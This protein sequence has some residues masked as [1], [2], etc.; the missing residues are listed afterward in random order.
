M[1]EKNPLFLPTSPDSAP[2]WVSGPKFRS[3]FDL[4]T[5]CILTLFLCVWTAVHLNIPG[6]EQ[7]R[8]SRLSQ[9]N[10]PSRIGW[11]LTGLIA[12]EIVL[13]VAWQQHTQAHI[14]L[15]QLEDEWS[16]DPAQVKSY[17]VG[18]PQ[19]RV[20][21]PVGSGPD[22]ILPADTANNGHDQERIKQA[23]TKK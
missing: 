7:R 15:S 22:S 23:Q 5:S 6:A 17:A 19:A 2:P 18:S 14:L 11:I 12:P 1:S 9:L 4:V 13:F 8:G 3:T 10:I 16:K 21:D 20:S